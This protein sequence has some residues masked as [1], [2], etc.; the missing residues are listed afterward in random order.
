LA[1][2]LDAL[3]HDGQCAEGGWPYLNALPADLAKWTPPATATPVY[4]RD[5]SYALPRVTDIIAQL[6][7][8]QPVVLTLLLGRRFYSPD[9][10]IVVVGPDDADI[11]WHA[12]IAIAHGRQEMEDFILVRNSWGAGWGL[13]GH[14]WISASYLEPRLH[15]LA[16]IS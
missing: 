15:Q 2:I 6:Q 13:E 3:K 10:G 11:D 1:T 14:A 7:A 12:V 5:A 9:S 8:G 4:R 16:L